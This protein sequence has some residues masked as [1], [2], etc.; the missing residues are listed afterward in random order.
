MNR[1]LYMAINYRHAN[2]KK[3]SLA[4]EISLSH[5][6]K[7]EIDENVY[8]KN[9]FYISV[10]ESWKEMNEIV[11]AWNENHKENNCLMSWDELT[12]VIK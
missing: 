5:N 6:F 8:I 10:C 7:K 11:E 2:E 9:A 12:E 3:R 1:V 4:V